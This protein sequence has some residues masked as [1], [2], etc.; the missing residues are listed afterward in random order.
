[1]FLHHVFL[2]VLLTLSRIIYFV[3]DDLALQ[4]KEFI[5]SSVGDDVWK[6]LEKSKMDAKQEDNDL[7]INLRKALSKTRLE[8]LEG[9]VIESTMIQIIDILDYVIVSMETLNFQ[10]EIHTKTIK[11]EMT[12]YRRFAAILDILFRDTMFDISDGEQ[13]SQ[14]TKDIMTRNSKTF[15]SAKYSDNVIGRRIDL[16]IRSSGTIR[17]MFSLHQVDDAFIAN[18]VSDLKLPMDFTQLESFIN[19]IDDYLYLKEIIEPAHRLYKDEISLAQLRTLKKRILL[20]ENDDG[21]D[22]EVQDDEEKEKVPYQSPDT[23]FS[24]RKKRASRKLDYQED[25]DEDI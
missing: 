15:S 19:T 21:D 1:M 5:M 16:M 13:T 25:S 4:V 7:K 17:Y 9:S 11:S 6:K 3:N 2:L 8:L 24:P 10:S 20:N 12:Y 23:F 22:E 14:I 18:H